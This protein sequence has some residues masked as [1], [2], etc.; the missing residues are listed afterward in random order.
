MKCS[1]ACPCWLNRHKPFTI[2]LPSSQAIQ[3]PTKTLHYCKV[4]QE[5]HYVSVTMDSHL[6]FCW[7]LANRAKFCQAYYTFRMLRLFTNEQNLISSHRVHFKACAALPVVAGHMFLMH[8]ISQPHLKTVGLENIATNL[9]RCTLYH[10]CHWTSPVELPSSLV[11][12]LS[13]LHLNH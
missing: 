2:L 1:F 7:G 5:L 4:G 10:I 13:E 8:Q 9:S 6:L 3:I 12:L 11:I